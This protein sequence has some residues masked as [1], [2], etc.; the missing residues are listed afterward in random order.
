MLA[1]RDLPDQH[2]E[3]IL[4]LVRA[5]ARD[6]AREDHATERGGDDP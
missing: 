6:A 1:L 4:A 2:R 3:Q 5:L